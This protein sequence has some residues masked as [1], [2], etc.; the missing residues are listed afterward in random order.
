MELFILLAMNVTTCESDRVRV[1]ELTKLYQNSR[2]VT[3]N[4]SG[5][6]ISGPINHWEINFANDRGVSSLNKKIRELRQE[7]NPTSVT[8]ILDWWWLQGN[9]YLER[10]G[11]HW[12]E[13]ASQLLVDNLVDRVYL[14]MDNGPRTRYQKEMYQGLQYMLDNATIPQCIVATPT[15]YDSN[16]LA[17]ASTTVVDHKGQTVANQMKEYVSRDAP[18]WLF[19]RREPS[20]TGVK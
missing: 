10:Y 12:V 4:E 16:P 19:Q 11:M 5:P 1:L 15:N 20:R 8:V 2:I 13:S 14:P 18:F 3:V 6:S 17:L 9:Y 7:L